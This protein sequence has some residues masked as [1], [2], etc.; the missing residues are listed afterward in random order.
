MELIGRNPCE[1]A[2][3][4]SIKRSNAK[5]LAGDEVRRLLETAR[6]TR[7]E[8]V[9]RARA[10]DRRA[11]RRAMRPLLGRLRRRRRTLTIRYSLSQTRR[12]IALKATKTGRTRTLPLSR[13]ANDALRSQRALQ[14]RERLANGG[15]YHNADD[16]I[17]ADEVG[18]RI[19]PMAAI[20]R[21]RAPRP[22]GG[23]LDD[24]AAR[25]AAHGSD[26][27]AAR[28]RRYSH[29]GWRTRPFIP[30]G[31]ALDLRASHAGSAAR[32]RRS[33]R[34]AP[35]T[36]RGGGFDAARQPNGNRVAASIKKS[37][38]IQAISGSANGNRTRDIGVPAAPVKYPIVLSCTG[39][40]VFESR[41]VPSNPGEF[42]G[43]R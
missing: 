23:D 19:T 11:T 32:S 37:L 8:A 12:G 4:P 36:P 17:F 5:A 43:I 21:V 10:L 35:R 26:D 40:R 30:D 28:R 39:F 33:P 34:R 6:G 3:R 29:R 42:C 22:Q 27:D 41:L 18:R 20:V 16:A 25:S 15:L 13:V 2:T 1:A 24:A 7:W 9:R 14:A 31:H 38:Q